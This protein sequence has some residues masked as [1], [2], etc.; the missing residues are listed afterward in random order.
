MPA[1]SPASTPPPT[2]RSARSAIVIAVVGAVVV[3][4]VVAFL[5]WRESEPEALAAGGEPGVIARVESL[6]N[7]IYVYKRS[8]G[9]YTLS[10]GAERLRYTESIVNPDDEL[11][12]PVY[13]TQSMTAGLAYAP[14]LEDAAIVGLGGGRTAWYHHKSVPGMHMT[15]VELDPAVAQI[16]D[17]F[18]SV[19]S[20]ENFDVEVMDGRV[21]LTKND[22]DFDIIMV[23]AYRGPFVPFHLLTTEFY[24]LVSQRLKPGG[25]VVQNVEP[26]TMLFDSA[27]ATIASAFDHLVFF[28]GSGNIVI[29]A[30]DGP[31]KDEAELERIAAERQAEYGFR[32]PLPEILKRRYMP[33]AT[34]AKP[35]TDDFAPVEYL[36][37]IERHNEKQT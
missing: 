24:E 10:F 11:D 8:N 27:V 6:Y 15:A 14:A 26:S 18:F 16:A 36:K 5:L 20:E 23:D 12:L 2:T 13:Y 4:A 21:W 33:E 7:D 9:F 19:R 34:T 3:A 35:L 1:K 17:Q 22:R 29:L 37:A 32:Y 30:Y 25:V 31:E 28:E